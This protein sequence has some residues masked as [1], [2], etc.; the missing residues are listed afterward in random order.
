WRNPKA[1]RWGGNFGRS[2]GVGVTLLSRRCAQCASL[3][4]PYDCVALM[5]FAP[6]Q[7]I[8]ARTSK[9]AGHGIKI[10]HKL[11]RLILWKRPNFGISNEINAVSGPQG[12]PQASPPRHSPVGATREPVEGRGRL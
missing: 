11:S 12:R 2:D 3:I 8:P 9:S 1:V 6:A 4:A 5:G 10:P 7:P